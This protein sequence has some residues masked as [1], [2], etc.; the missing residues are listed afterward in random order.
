MVVAATATVVVVVVHNNDDDEVETVSM[1]A[2]VGSS[3]CVGGGCGN[4]VDGGMRVAVTVEG[5]DESFHLDDELKPLWG[6]ASQ[7]YQPFMSQDLEGAGLRIEET[8][9]GKERMEQLRFTQQR[10]LEAQMIA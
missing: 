5:V 1:V 2:V 4:D 7:S 8:K 3:S 6:V 9:D 10:E